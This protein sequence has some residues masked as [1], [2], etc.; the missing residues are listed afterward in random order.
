MSNVQR[1]WSFAI[2]LA[3]V[4]FFL[5]AAAS[6]IIGNRSDNFFLWIVNQVGS[7][8]VLSWW[9][10]VITLIVLLSSLGV[11]FYLIYHNRVLN[12]AL[13]TANHIIDLDD[14]VLRLLA[15]WIPSKNHDNEMKQLLAELLRDAS[16]EFAGHVHRAFILTPDDKKENLLIW[17]H[18]GIPQE[19]IDR[20]K[21]YI[22]VD[23]D[24]KPLQ[25]VAG[26]VY[27]ERKLRVGHV[28][29]QENTWR[30]DCD[31]Y[32]KFDDG[33]HLPPYRSFACIPI[34]GPDLD[35]PRLSATVCLGV[36]I[37]D[38]M[39]SKV[40]DTSESQIVLRIFAR[41]IATALIMN[42]LLP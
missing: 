20:K 14:S 5:G 22:G 42:R 3:I 30:T 29:Q 38:S 18:I 21:F 40:F 32:I 10:W 9:P 1:H 33:K 8:V 37:F 17:A 12:R 2:L 36:A 13:V 25:G 24:K 39:D 15:S 7:S 41:R 4:T 34:I 16:A 26:N 31:C 23:Q 19:S 6:G 11:I 28:L 27:L 35:S